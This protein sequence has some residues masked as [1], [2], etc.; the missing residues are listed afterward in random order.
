V[1][2]LEGFWR[3]A[4]VI[5]TAM[6]DYIYFNRMEGDDGAWGGAIVALGRMG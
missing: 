2:A 3:G 4:A 6:H 5:L 1:E